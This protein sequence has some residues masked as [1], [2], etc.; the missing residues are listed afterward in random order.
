VQEDEI[1]GENE[2]TRPKLSRR[3]FVKTT[4]AGIGASAL[5]GIGA[6]P[7][8]AAS[9]PRRWDKVADVVVV[10]AG[11]TGLPASIEAAENG[12][13]V[14]LIDQN[15]DIGGH[16]IESGGNIALG[17]GT[18]LQ[19]KYGIEDSPDRMFSDLAHWHDY[20]FSDREIVRA[21]CDWSAPTLEWLIAH[22]VVFPDQSPGGADGGPQNV[23]RAQT[24]LWN[25]GVSTVAPTGA[26]GTALMRPLEASARKLGVQIL[27]QHSLTSIVRENNFSGRVLGI[28]ATNEGKTVNIQAKK[29]VIIGTGGH[30]SNVNFRR[31]FDPRLTE[32]YQVVGEPYSRQTGDGEVAAMQVGASLWGAANQTV[33]TMARSHIFEKPSV[34]G[35][36][37]GY[38]QGGGSR[39]EDLKDSPLFH[40]FRAI[41]LLVKDYQNLIHVNQAGVRFV[42][43]A[44]T[45]FDWWNP[46]LEWHG[47]TGEGGG[48][49]W[50][51][52]DAD[53]AKR[54]GWVC[55]PP[56]VDAEGWFFSG[57]TVAELAAR[58]VSKYQKQPM[59]AGALQDTINRYNSF[60]DAGKDADF[61]KPAPKYQIQTPPF[62]A[63][64]ST[65]CV[66]DCLSGLRIN[67]K[68]QVVDLHGQVIPGLYCGG[69]SAGGFNQHGLAKCLVEGRIAGREAARSSSNPAVKS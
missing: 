49:I 34:I 66:H 57:R 15:Y 24:V 23:K 17:G 18:S 11:A 4:A 63:A 40:Q 27:L 59:P 1:M 9:V 10:G 33:E 14:I 56:Y 55:A 39:S 51:I 43:E 28:T 38:P 58:I 45:G 50:A 69:E 36:Q 68:A 32:E 31:M 30:S 20:R 6:K 44:A 12:A 41:G 3:A 65:P 42:N 54:E 26:N 48:P 60:V 52:F 16:A 64:W 5:A 2:K 21:F 8:E 62:Y 53:G 7:A 61:G 29:G 19:R 67:A 22:G 25:G 35:S 47:G 13:S 46:C 37:Y